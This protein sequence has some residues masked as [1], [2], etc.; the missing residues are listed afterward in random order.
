MKSPPLINS[1]TQKEEQDFAETII[2]STQS[3]KEKTRRKIRQGVFDDRTGDS[4]EKLRGRGS[5]DELLEPIAKGKEAN[6]FLGQKGKEFVAV[7]IYRIETTGFYKRGR[8][9]FEDDEIKRVGTNIQ[10]MIYAWAQ[11]EFRNLQIAKENNVCVP[12][13]IDVENNIVVMELIGEDKPKETLKY[14]SKTEIAKNIKEI[15]KQTVQNLHNLIYKAKLIH[16]DLS[17]YNLIFFNKKLYL[18]DMGQTGCVKLPNAKEFV[19]RD[20][21][22]LVKFFNSF[23]TNITEEKMKADI[24]AGKI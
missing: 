5:I 16:A 8:Y 19:Q 13:P 15:Y 3:E 24:K 14:T 9:L 1:A 17:E 6:I 18:I 11:K 10:R 7:K 20:I 2:K 4:L 23:D 22:N 12:E 21:R